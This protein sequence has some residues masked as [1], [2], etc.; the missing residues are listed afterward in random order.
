MPFA[1]LSTAITGVIS[2]ARG[3]KSLNDFNQVAQV[4]SDLLERILTI[5]GEALTL[6]ESHLSLLNSKNDL[7]KK[8]L[9]YEQ[10]D[11]TASQYSLKKLIGRS[12]VCIP[13]ESNKTPKPMHYLC[14]KCY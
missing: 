6:Q 9:S 10:W 4:S 1:E 5:Q 14:A 12:F 7:E 3:L 8:L 13:N 11:N 2:I